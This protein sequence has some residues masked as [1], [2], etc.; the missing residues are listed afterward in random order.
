MKKIIKAK[1]IITLVLKKALYNIE[2]QKLSG[3]KNYEIQ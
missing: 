2:E 3:S 1:K